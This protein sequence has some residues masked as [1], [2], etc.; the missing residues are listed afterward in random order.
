[1]LCAFGT[2]GLTRCLAST[3]RRRP[4]VRL[5]WRAEVAREHNRPAYV[6]FHDATL[7]TIAALAPQTLEAYGPEMLRV[8]LLN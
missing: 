1:M 6:T 7:A 5:A 8:S 2:S 3:G 4:G